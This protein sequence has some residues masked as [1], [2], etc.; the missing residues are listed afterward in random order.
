MFKSEHQRVK[1]LLSAYLDGELSPKEADLVERHLRECAYCAQDLES[2]RQ[3]VS[4][5]RQLP[6]VSPPPSF[7]VRLP[8]A[9]EGFLARWGY[10]Y[11][12]GTTALAALLLVVL[13]ASDLTLQYQGMARYAAPPPQP[14][15][16][17][18]EATSEVELKAEAATEGPQP[19]ATPPS[20]EYAAERGAE[21]ETPTLLN[22]AAPEATAPITPTLTTGV[23]PTPVPTLGPSPTGELSLTPTP[24]LEPSPTVEA[25]TPTPE[26]V[27]MMA[28]EPPS[29]AFSIPWLRPLEVVTL[30][31]FLFLLAGTIAWRRRR[32][33]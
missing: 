7:R 4:L 1:E 19:E 32:S 17:A 3:T 20:E 13:L 24:T 28:Q 8:M 6:V 10:A 30:A 16:M 27:E 26:A 23:S 22:Q 18:P 11:L 29:Q 5:V 33:P 21:A 14:L 2:L 25:P 15:V 31:S 12:K 9:Q